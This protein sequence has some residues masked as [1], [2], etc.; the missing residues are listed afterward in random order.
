M[1]IND[2]FNSKR[3]LKNVSV[4]DIGACLPLTNCAPAHK[5]PA[6][7]HHHQ[8][9]QCLNDCKYRSISILVA[10]SLSVLHAASISGKKGR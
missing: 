3:L 8:G 9:R 2:T 10:P 1:K 5:K 6:T 7:A 4:N